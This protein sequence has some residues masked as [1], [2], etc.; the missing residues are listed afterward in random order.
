MKCI[1][2]ETSM[3]SCH[4]KTTSQYGYSFNKEIEGLGQS[5]LRITNMKNRI[6]K[7]HLN[8]FI[9]KLIQHPNNNDLYKIEF[10]YNMKIEIDA[11]CSLREVMHYIIC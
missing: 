3:Q 5:E 11:M 10:L 7:Y 9:V 4:E 8:I 2:F 6:T 1:L